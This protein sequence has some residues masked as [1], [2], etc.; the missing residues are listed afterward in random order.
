MWPE[1]GLVCSLP[2]V[3]QEIQLADPT[4][5]LYLPSRHAV[6][7]SVDVVMVPVNPAAHSQLVTPTLPKVDTLLAG[8]WAHVP[9]WSYQSA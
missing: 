4:E 8:H 9:S 5:A 3:L 6:H 2:S 1:L 7:V